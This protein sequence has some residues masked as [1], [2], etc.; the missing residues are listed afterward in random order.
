V[1]VIDEAGGASLKRGRPR[2]RYEQGSRWGEERAT[3]AV[4]LTLTGCKEEAV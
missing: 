3:L 1:I 2:V 4:A